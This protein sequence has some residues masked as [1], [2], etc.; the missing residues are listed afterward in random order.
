[1]IKNTLYTIIIICSFGFSQTTHTINAGMN[2]SSFYF[3][4][5]D[6]TIEQGDVVIWINDG[7]CHDVNGNINS[8]T[9]SPFGNPETFDSPTTC[10]TGAEIFSYTFNTPGNYNY[11]C[12]VGSH[13]ANGMVGSISVTSNNTTVVDII[14]DSDNHNTLEAAVIAA[15]LD[16]D[17]SGDGPFTVFAPTDEAFNALPEGTVATLLEDPTGDLANI[18]LHHVYAGSALSTDLSDGM[19]IQTLFGTE[20]NVSIDGGSVMIDNAMVTVANIEADN[21]VVHV[22]NAVLIPSTEPTTV[23]D[24][25]VDSDNHNTLEAAVIAAELDDDLS[26]DGPFTVFAPTDEAFN[27]LPEGTVATLLE[28]PTGDL[29]NILLHHVYA[30]SALSTDL[31]DGMMIQTLFGTELNVS[32]DG[33]SVMID[34]A[35]VTVANIEADN[36]VVHIINAV[37]IPQDNSNIAEINF[38]DHIIQTVD[39]YGRITKETIKNSISIDLY[40]SGKSI[41]KLIIT[42]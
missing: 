42:K 25:I 7:G 21:G 28:D 29:A 1:M 3:N 39:I 20:L 15:E 23:V 6:L 10:D 16:D 19:M 35:M 22:I 11:D 4:P 2:G 31:S 12:S 40:Q 24:I 37:L 8:I 13:A 32:I 30:G 38:N 14:V 26:G 18:L 33:G 27:A 36:G 5:S 17:L 41:K 9:N 34:N